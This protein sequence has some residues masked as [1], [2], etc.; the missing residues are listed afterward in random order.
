[1]VNALFEIQLRILIERTLIF[2]LDEFHN[3]DFAV[4]RTRGQT[5]K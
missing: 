4:L 3:K 2:G 1:M 5:V